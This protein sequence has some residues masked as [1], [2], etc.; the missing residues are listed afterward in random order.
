MP[1]IDTVFDQL[2][3]NAVRG[4]LSIGKYNISLYISFTV[5]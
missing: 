2:T 1:F 4:E 5:I 3:G